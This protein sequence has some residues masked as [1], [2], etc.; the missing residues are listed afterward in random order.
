M[1][2]REFE[3]RS[4]ADGAELD[5]WLAEHG[6]SAPGLY[7]RLARKGAGFASVTWEELVEGLICH[8]WIDGRGNRFDDESWTVRVTPRRPRSVWSAKN[9]AT[10]ARLVDAGRMRPAGLAQVQAAQADGRWAAAYP[11]SA[12]MPVPDDLAA[13][14]AATPGA[15]AAFDAL[16]AAGRYSVLYRVHTKRTAAGRASAIA[17]AVGRLTDPDGS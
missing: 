11:G 16:D 8:G 5:A 12:A 1:V 15:Q 10:V 6:A 3:V 14:L 4:F 2:E 9:V 13:A 7:V 17:D